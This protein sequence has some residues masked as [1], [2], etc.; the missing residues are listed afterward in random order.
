[1]L[2]DVRVSRIC[3]LS[4][5]LCLYHFDIKISIMENV[6]W[7]K[8]TI[9]LTLESATTMKCVVNLETFYIEKPVG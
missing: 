9:G 8:P 5:L 3:M 4:T 1:M 6:V 2:I 7:R